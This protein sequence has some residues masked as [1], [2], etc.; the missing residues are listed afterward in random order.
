MSSVTAVP[1]QPVKRRYITYLVIG[2]LL[3]VVGAAALAWQAPVDFLAGNAKKPGVVTTASGLQYQVITPGAGAKPTETDVAL[4]NYVGKL[5]D[6]TVFD[7]SQQPTPLP[8]AGVVPG[9]SEAL[10]LMP[11]GAKYRV[12]IKPE[13]GYGDKDSGPIPANS[14]LDFEIELLDFLPESVIRQMQM[15][16]MQQGGMPGGMPGGAPAPAPPPGR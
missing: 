8:V 7:Q 1:I 5:T 6:G 13:L 9:F 2:L 15:Q 11:K 10:K 12:W 14:V 4:I 16:Q 3:A